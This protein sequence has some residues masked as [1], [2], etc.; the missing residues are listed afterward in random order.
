MRCNTSTRYAPVRWASGLKKG[1]GKA[2]AGADAA[3]RSF[4]TEGQGCRLPKCRDHQGDR[5]AAILETWPSHWRSP[6]PPRRWRTKPRINEA[7]L[8]TCRRILPPTG[9]IPTPHGRGS[10]GAASTR[11]NGAFVNKSVILNGLSRTCEP[12]GRDSKSA[13]G[14]RYCY[15]T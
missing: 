15:N 3:N 1:T 8:G 4:G 12:S 9:K 14:Y 2:K 13:F 10:D 6:T 11:V 5:V 7:W